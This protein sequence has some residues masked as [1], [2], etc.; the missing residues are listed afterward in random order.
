MNLNEF[1]DLVDKTR[2]ESQDDQDQHLE[3]MRNALAALP[4][5]EILD[6]ERLFDDLMDRA[7]THDLWAAAYILNG[8][9]SQDGFMD[10]RAWLISQGQSV[11]GQALNNPESLVDRVACEEFV[12]FERFLSVSWHAWEQ[13]TGVEFPHESRELPKLTGDDWDEDDLEHKYPKLWAKH[14]PWLDK[15]WILGDT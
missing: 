3:L 15:K 11:Y 9:C 10:F 1:W 4:E 8:G 13:K 6:Y 2:D 12:E 5:Q 7:Y 14:H